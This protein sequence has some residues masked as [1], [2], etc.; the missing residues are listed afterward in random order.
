MKVFA[1]INTLLTYK[2]YKAKLD[3]DYQKLQY[4]R[5]IGDTENIK[6]AIQEV[7]EDRKVMGE[8]LDMEV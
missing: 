5:A 7:D 6:I 4:Y 8:F 1:I 3:N 2:R